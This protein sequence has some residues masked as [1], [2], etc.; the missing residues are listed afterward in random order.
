MLRTTLTSICQCPNHQQGCCSQAAAGDGVAA[1]ILSLGTSIQTSGG[2]G[3]QESSRAAVSGQER[4]S[5]LF[6]W[7]QPTLDPGVGRLTEHFSPNPSASRLACLLLPPRGVT[8]VGG[9]HRPKR[10]ARSPAVFKPQLGVL[11]SCPPDNCIQP[12]DE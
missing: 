11:L 12:M 10:L 1:H 4:H 2:P 3:D 9:R 6:S 8:W 5:P 7:P